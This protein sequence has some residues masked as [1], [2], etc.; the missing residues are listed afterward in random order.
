MVKIWLDDTRD[1]AKHAHVG[2]VWVKTA[3]DCITYLS[4]FWNEISEISLDHDLGPKA[5]LGLENHGESTGYDV[6]VWIEER[7]I[8]DGWKLPVIHVH[9]QNPSGKKRIE[10]A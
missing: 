1:P 3:E 4:A 10:A 2:L 8:V 6:A 7:V 5:T 9:S